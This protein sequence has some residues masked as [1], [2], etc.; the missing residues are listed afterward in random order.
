MAGQARLHVGGRLG[1]RKRRKLRAAAPK[2]APACC[3]TPAGE[4]PPEL[5][6]TAGA[7]RDSSDLWEQMQVRALE[8][9]PAHTHALQRPIAA[10][11][12][13]LA[14][15]LRFCGPTAARRRDT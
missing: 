9:A 13:R 2:G 8:V 5:Q 14:T 12:P 11:G 10:S 15:A 6:Y 1:Q 7:A 4:V 3:S